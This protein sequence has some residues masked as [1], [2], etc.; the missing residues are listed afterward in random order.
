MKKEKYARALDLDKNTLIL[1]SPIP[2]YFRL[3]A[4]DGQ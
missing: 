4:R 1:A 3:R 2:D